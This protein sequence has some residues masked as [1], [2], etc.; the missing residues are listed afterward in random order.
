MRLRNLALVVVLSLLPG[1]AKEDTL[2]LQVP[3]V[4]TPQQA[5]RI[6][7]VYEHGNDG[8]KQAALSAVPD[9][10]VL[11]TPVP[12]T[13]AKKEGCEIYIL[14]SFSPT[15]PL[16]KVP[17]RGQSDNDDELI[18]KMLLGNINELRQYISTYKRQLKQSHDDYLRNCSKEM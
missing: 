3:V 18:D 7:V 1:C 10:P 5:S 8:W 6:V 2:R 12:T 15:P 17:Q 14:P 13:P 16:P 4:E 11:P 9:R